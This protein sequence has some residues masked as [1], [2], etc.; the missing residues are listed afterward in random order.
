MKNSNKK[1]YAVGFQSNINCGNAYANRFEKQRSYDSYKS[2][3]W[4]KCADNSRKKP[5]YNGFSV[6][7][8]HKKSTSCGNI[9]EK[10]KTLLKAS[11]RRMDTRS[12]T[13]KYYTMYRD[14]VEAP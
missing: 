13:T 8:T 2:V 12:T 10:A 5:I 14:D 9:C 7:N 3:V 1:H 11:M 6:C 4:L